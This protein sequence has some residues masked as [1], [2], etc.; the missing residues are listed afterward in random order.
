M[1]LLRHSDAARRAGA[2][3]VIATT[4]GLDSYG[5]VFGDE[6]RYRYM[7][8]KARLP[9]DICVLPDFVSRLADDVTGPVIVYEQSPLHLRADFDFRRTDRHIWTDSPYMLAKCAAVFPG[10]KIPIVP[11]VV[12]AAL[13][14]FIPQDQRKPGLLFAY[15]RKN[16]EFIAET[17]QHYAALG[18]TYWRFEL[19]DGLSIAELAARLREPQVFL[20]SARYEGCALPPQ[21]AMAA[22]VVVVGRTAQGANFSMQDGVTALN[23]ETPAEA[24]RRLV[25]LESAVLRERIAAAARE[26]ISRFFPDEAPLAFWKSA[27]RDLMQ[28]PE[29]S[30]AESVSPTRAA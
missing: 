29:T 3:V 27:L 20:A 12:D 4:D 15:P 18:G 9:T 6:R 2:E 8:W 24:A 14:P 28:L 17:H 1:N 30:R 25:E 5:A 22:G 7:P 16:P 21:E 19:V 23:A 13:F 11:N 10:K 26:Y